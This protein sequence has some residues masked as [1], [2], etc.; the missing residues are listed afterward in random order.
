MSKHTVI[1]VSPVFEKVKEGPAIYARYLYDHFL[2]HDFIEFHV[3]TLGSAG[4]S[5]LIHFS[6]QPRG[7]FQSYTSLQNT[8]IDLLKKHPNALLHG[9]YAHGVWKFA[10][11]S[12]PVILQVNDY[13]PAEITK[14]APSYIRQRQYRR[15][16]SL[17]WRRYNEKNAVMN[18]D[19][20]ICNSQYTLDSIAKNYGIDRERCQVIYKAVECDD[21]FPPSASENIS[22]VRR[23]LFVGSNWRR[24]GLRDLLLALPEVKRVFPDITLDIVGP[25]KDDIQENLASEIAAGNIS[26]NL[27]FSGR[28]DRERL[29]GHYHRADLFILP[30]Y[31]EALGVVLLES[32]ASGVP[33]VATAVG[34]I[35]EVVGDSSAG[36]L[37]EPGN[38]K[39]L[40]RVITDTLE[41]TATL[42]NMRFACLDRAN[43]F[44]VKKMC[45]EVEKMYVDVASRSGVVS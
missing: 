12:N 36:K 32:M 33:I 42:K 29:A 22:P 28:V 25:E 14:N 39:Q 38:V 2:D 10:N 4:N 8:A 6:G 37:V 18:A 26:E 45:A 13:D 40:A 11:V 3:V 23:L 20:V 24:K 16:L 15:M 19:R 7:S 1:F 44:S 43:D 31:F 41:D 17:F 34:G 5:E 27:V 9:N 35:P 30:S 21:F